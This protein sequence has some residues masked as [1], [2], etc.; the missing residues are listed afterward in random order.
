MNMHLCEAKCNFLGWSLAVKPY[1]WFFFSVLEIIL[2]LRLDFEVDICLG[3]RLSKQ[4]IIPLEGKIGWIKTKKG[5]SIP[6]IVHF[7]MQNLK[8]I[9]R[10]FLG[11]SATE[12][13]GFVWN[14]VFQW[15]WNS[16]RKSNICLIWSGKN[17]ICSLDLPICVSAFVYR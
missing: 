11:L 13:A 9:W 3:F 5:H 12:R 4:I 14:K 16:Y 7:W 6:L 17:L 2:C 8:K 15:S 10:L 1:L